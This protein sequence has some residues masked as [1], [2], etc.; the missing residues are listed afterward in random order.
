[1]VHLH[2]LDRLRLER[3][4]EHLHALGARTQAEFLAELAQRIGGMPACLALLAEYENL[5]TR[6]LRAAGGDRFPGRPLRT[7]AA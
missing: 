4:A 1:M 6:A 5:S 2:P 7:V 3:G